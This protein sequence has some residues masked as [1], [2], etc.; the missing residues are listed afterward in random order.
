MKKINF[1]PAIRYLLV[2]TFLT[3]LF[4]TLLG[5]ATSNIQLPKPLPPIVKEYKQVTV[6]GGRPGMKNTGVYLRP[7]AVYSI[8]A[9]GQID[10]WTVRPGVGARLLTPPRALSITMSGRSWG[11]R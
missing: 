8:L 10:F 3:L 7:G 6:V 9:T 2:C 11:G 1:L 5:C 4:L